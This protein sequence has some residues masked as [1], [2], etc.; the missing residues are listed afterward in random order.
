[1]HH[2]S[3]GGNSPTCSPTWGGLEGDEINKSKIKIQLIREI[4][5]ASYVM[6]D[7]RPDEGDMN[8]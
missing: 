7:K 8:A 2:L 4:V 5:K 1:M 6:S 3:N